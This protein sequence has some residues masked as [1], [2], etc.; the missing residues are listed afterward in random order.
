MVD[1]KKGDRVRLIDTKDFD[2]DGPPVGT[3]GT[4]IDNNESIPM[5]DWDDFVYQHATTIDRSYF[6]VWHNEL[7]LI[8]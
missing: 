1:F 5:V 6:A 8:S 4:V 2:Y 7:E 3:Q